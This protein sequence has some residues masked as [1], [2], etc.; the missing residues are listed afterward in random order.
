[1][2]KID[3][4]KLLLEFLQTAPYLD[5]DTQASDMPVIDDRS[6]IENTQ[7][8]PLSIPPD[9]I[10]SEEQISFDLA[11]RIKPDSNGINTIANLIDGEGDETPIGDKD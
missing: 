3:A 7:N 4:N 2:N 8:V 9:K 1:M 5:I 6:E 10:P 11:K